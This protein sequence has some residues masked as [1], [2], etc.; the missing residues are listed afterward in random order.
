MTLPALVSQSAAGIWPLLLSVLSASLLG[1]LHCVMMCGPLV[2]VYSTAGCGENSSKKGTVHAAYHLG[3][4]LV[5]VGVGAL[6]GM[7]G[8]YLNWAG[9]AAGIARVAALLASGL[10]VLWGLGVLVPRLRVPGPFA[11]LIGPQLIR[12]RGKPPLIRASLLGVLT[13]LLPCGWF[14]AF[15][16]TA[17]GTGGAMTGAWVM[18]AFWLG[19]VP[20]LLGMG[21][22]MSR[23][24]QSLRQKVPFVTGV[25]LIVVGLFG[26]V[27]RS[28]NPLT[29]STDEA[30]AHKEGTPPCH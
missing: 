5:Y 13:P 25:A 7:A 23:L 2:A 22:L 4:G 3:R 16:L 12:L 24:G 10:L 20:A 14:Y 6:G 11:H 18:F 1:S 19:T 15:A 30:A 29:M 9:E 27:T 21:A 26:V 8:S 17:A 28:M